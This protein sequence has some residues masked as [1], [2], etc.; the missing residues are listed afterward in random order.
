M[1]GMTSSNAIARTA[2][3]TLVTINS[4]TEPGDKQ[5][6]LDN[7]TGIAYQLCAAKNS[8]LNLVKADLPDL[9]KI[10][11]EQ[12]N[13]ITATRFNVAD[14]IR[15]P[16]IINTLCSQ[17]TF[18]AAI[19]NRFKAITDLSPVEK[20]QY[21]QLS[22][23]EK[24]SQLRAAL[25]SL[26]N[27][28]LKAP[29]NLM[30]EEWETYGVSVSEVDTQAYAEFKQF[31]DEKMQ[32]HA[33]KKDDYAKL[34]FAS[35]NIKTHISDPRCLNAKLTPLQLFKAAYQLGAVPAV[36]NFRFMNNPA[37]K[38]DGKYR[39]WMYH[40]DNSNYAAE[41]KLITTRTAGTDQAND[42]QCLAAFPYDTKETIRFTR[43]E[44][45]TKFPT[46]EELQ[47]E[48]S[49]V[50]GARYV[51]VH[52]PNNSTPL[53]TG[54]RTE[55]IPHH[56]SASGPDEFKPR[57]AE[58][59]TFHDISR[60]QPFLTQQELNQA[61]NLSALQHFVLGGFRA[62]SPQDFMKAMSEQKD[63]LNAQIKQALETKALIP[64]E[65]ITVATFDSQGTHPLNESLFN[66]QLSTY[67]N[68]PEVLDKI[69]KLSSY[70]ADW[71]KT[72]L[73]IVPLLM[74][75]D[76]NA[77]LKPD[78]SEN[79]AFP[80]RTEL[81]ERTNE[82][83]SL[84]LE[85]DLSN[86]QLSNDPSNLLGMD[87]LISLMHDIQSFYQ[88]NIPY[89]KGDSKLT[90]LFHSRAALANE[91]TTQLP[92]RATHPETHQVLSLFAYYMVDDLRKL[93]NEADNFKDLKNSMLL[94][95]IT[96]QQ[97]PLLRHFIAYRLLHDQQA[98]S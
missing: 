51:V 40:F 92:S 36:S 57:D 10:F 39:E 71:R 60:C 38:D 52:N 44:A 14:I 55:M 11:S 28:D 84:P 49:Q 15:N 13:T 87:S 59:M 68:L 42:Q 66:K 23:S 81:R 7:T 61:D 5:Y 6:V 53:E 12:S 35:Q 20:S 9:K 27:Q 85:R 50:P 22:D 63:V 94:N 46:M 69:P 37:S 58:L 29:V 73:T 18:S 76:Q 77:A 30:L 88:E 96:A 97:L 62:A 4:T 48:F 3:H 34:D 16:S 24:A 93:R 26:V 56:R 21:K 75:Y 32:E 25:L 8:T 80:A 1:P 47:K 67:E 98:N 65:K 70:S 79:K 45:A 17:Y 43:S 83:F 64:L 33:V 74:N 91:Y 41:F 72:V 78:C 89:V 86:L 31:Y 19:P 54:I 95:K 2:N 82:A 90:A